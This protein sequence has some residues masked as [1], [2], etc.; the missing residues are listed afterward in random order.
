MS[1]EDEAMR[2]LY[3]LSLRP[4]VIAIDVALGAL[5]VLF[6]VVLWRLTRAANRQSQPPATPHL[7]PARRSDGGRAA[8]MG[9]P[10]RPGPI[11]GTRVVDAG[12][13]LV[14]GS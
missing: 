7:R 9:T 2:W 5:L 11:S 10:L 8:G 12:R 4:S 6:L 14:G 3:A 13:R 1:L